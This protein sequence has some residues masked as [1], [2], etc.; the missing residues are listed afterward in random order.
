MAVQRPQEIYAGAAVVYIG[1]SFTPETTDITD[2]INNGAGYSATDTTLVVDDA[3]VIAPNVWETSAGT[4]ADPP[5]VD[6]ILNVNTR[7]IMYCYS[8]TDADEEINV[9]RGGS[10]W[11]DKQRT[12][13]TTYALAITDDDELQL[14]GTG[15]MPDWSD[16]IVF[17]DQNVT[18][19]SSYDMFDARDNIRGLSDRYVGSP[20]ATTL[21]C[22]IPRN[23]I[24]QFKSLIGRQRITDAQTSNTSYMSPIG[25][26][27]AGTKIDGQFIVVVPLEQWTGA[28]TFTIGA[29][30]YRYHTRAFFLPYAMLDPSETFDYAEGSQ[31]N[32][33]AMFGTKQD[34]VFC[35]Q[36][37]QGW[38]RDAHR[39]LKA[40]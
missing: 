34:N 29:N 21:E 4:I 2:A 15:T 26:L 25:N 38:L 35:M 11:Y 27:A 30:E 5:V 6:V 10:L 18:I 32:I 1:S 16:G 31:L 37:F 19:T 33:P 24:P 20:A 23:T 13:D 40:E 9:V 36:A 7:E 17:T 8:R 28:D 12:S 22:T 3:S 39:L 14:L